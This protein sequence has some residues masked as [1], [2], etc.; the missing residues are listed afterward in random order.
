VKMDNKGKKT[1]NRKP[2]GKT[3]TELVGAKWNGYW[4]ETISI[5]W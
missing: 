4:E 3:E 5:W 2:A 1:R